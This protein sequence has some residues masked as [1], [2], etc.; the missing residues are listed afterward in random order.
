MIG[1]EDKGQ[2]VCNEP[3]AQL[4][5]RH[6]TRN[7]GLKRVATTATTVTPVA[8]YGAVAGAMETETGAIATGV[9]VADIGGIGLDGTVDFSAS[10]EAA[11]TTTKG[12][13]AA[14]AVAVAVA[15][16]DDRKDN[17]A[18][19]ASAATTVG[20]AELANA[21]AD[22]DAETDA[23]AGTDEGGAVLPS[24]DINMAV[25]LALGAATTPSAAASD[26]AGLAFLGVLFFFSCCCCTSAA[27]V[28]ID[29]I[30]GPADDGV[31]V[32]VAVVEDGAKGGGDETA[33]AV[34]ERGG[35]GVIPAA[36]INAAR[37]VPLD[38]LL[39]SITSSG[40]SPNACLSLNSCSSSCF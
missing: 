12:A 34:C 11:G 9:D 6:H 14:V 15:L 40:I 33:W 28:R 7:M 23:G 3:L 36:S 22:T 30:E 20:P 39:E 17:N 1:M 10:N 13:V 19:P 4:P 26:L 8:L 38:F 37:P 35:G 2:N 5:M 16:G 31:V 25:L 32:V 18:L 24:I 29:A 27:R 21:V